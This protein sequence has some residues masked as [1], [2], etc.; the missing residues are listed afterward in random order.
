MTDHQIDSPAQPPPAAK[1]TPS[2]VVRFSVAA[3]WFGAAPALAAFVA[4]RWLLPPRSSIAE[5]GWGWLAD[6]GA[7][8][9]L[10]LAVGFFLV[11]TV[12]ARVWRDRLPFGRLLAQTATDARHPRTLPQR[13]TSVAMIALVALAALTLRKSVAGVYEVQGPSMLP[14]LLPGDTLLVNKLSG[15]PFRRGD[16]IAFLAPAEAKSGPPAPVRERLVKRV[17]GL[18]GDRIKMRAGI[19]SIN[20]WEVPHCDAGT[21]VRYAANGTLVGRLLVEFLEDRVFLA[22]HVPGTRS[23]DS[24]EVKP[25]ELFVLGDDRSNSDDSRA[26]NGGRG[27]GVRLAAVEGRPWRVIGSDVEGRVDLGRLLE[28]PGLQL[29][30]PGMDVRGLE[31]GLERCLANRPKSTWPPPPPIESSA[32]PA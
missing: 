25:G 5:P 4:M 2:G 32:P 27:A 31:S 22:V 6:L 23:F 10:P 26:W 14:T 19:P 16:L 24:Y 3:W 17:I 18:P 21:F 9:S 12:V 15:G 28:K 30:M 8:H 13:I 7:N 20:G 29:N 11:F 1:P